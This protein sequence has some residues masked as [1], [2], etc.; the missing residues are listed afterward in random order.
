M[1]NDINASTII[2]EGNFSSSTGT[3]LKEEINTKPQEVFQSWLVGPRYQII[4]SL[5][6]GSYGD[7]VEAYDKKYNR[8]VAIKRLLNIFLNS[9]QQRTDV[10][11]LYREIRILR[12][13]NHPQI[14]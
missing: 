9:S 14:I 3:F 11:R 5:G 1:N 13:M 6:S 7:V 12:N 4:R 10:K 8:K 2:K